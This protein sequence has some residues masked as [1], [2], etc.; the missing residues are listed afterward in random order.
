MIFDFIIWELSVR[1]EFD[2]YFYF[3][4]LFFVLFIYLFICLFIYLF[5][6]LFV[7]L[8]VYL[9]ICLF[10]CLFNT[11]VFNSILIFCILLN[12]LSHF[13]L[14]GDRRGGGGGAV[15]VCDTYQQLLKGRTTVSGALLYLLQLFHFNYFI[16]I[17]LL[18][19][20]FLLLHYSPFF[21]FL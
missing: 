6:Y 9:F 20:I 3:Q 18:Y 8:F 13:F 10:I 19:T 7:Y 12:I 5:F 17:T 15:C 2:C 21:D 1:G 4:I 11:T 16:L 14:Q